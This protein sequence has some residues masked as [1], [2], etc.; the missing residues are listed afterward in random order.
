[1]HIAMIDTRVGAS[2]SGGVG[3]RVEKIDGLLFERSHE[4]TVFCRSVAGE[5]STS[6]LRG[7]R[8]VLLPA[9]RPRA[10]ETPSHTGLSV[11]KLSLGPTH[12]A[13]LVFAA[14]PWLPALPSGGVPM[15]TH[16]EGLEF[17]RGEWG[18]R[19][20]LECHAAESMSVHYWHCHSFCGANLSLLRAVGAFAASDAFNVTFN[21]GVLHDSGRDWSTT[22][23]VSQLLS[24][25]GA[26]P[27]LL[28]HLRMLAG[29]EASRSGWDDV[30][31]V[32]QDLPH[33]LVSGH[34]RRDVVA[35]VRRT[36]ARGGVAA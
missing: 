26:D 30:A 28:K 2:R 17:N 31:T 18:P 5:L 25:S 14:A 6:H 12:D 1:M 32:Q 8:L 11:A 7:L 34:S 13:A 4:I 16:V 10:L 23:A 27:L 3:T 36:A 15:T 19:A 29:Q 22:A 9:I 20:Q 24:S 21:C 35:S 33:R